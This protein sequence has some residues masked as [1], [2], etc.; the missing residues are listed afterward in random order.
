MISKPYRFGKVIL[1]PYAIGA[2]LLI[3]EIGDVAPTAIKIAVNMI[4]YL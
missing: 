4:R 3:F 2:K 1:S